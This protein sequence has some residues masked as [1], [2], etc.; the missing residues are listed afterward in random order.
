MWRMKAD[1]WQQLEKIFHLALERAPQ[2]RAAFWMKL[3][4][5]AMSYAGNQTRCSLLMRTPE[6]SLRDRESVPRFKDKRRRPH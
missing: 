2:D 5:S 6:V 3:V 4:P 1:Q